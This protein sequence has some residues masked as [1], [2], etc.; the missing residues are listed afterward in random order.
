MRKAVS[1][2]GGGGG[3]DEEKKKERLLLLP[4]RNAT[5]HPTRSLASQLAEER[6]FSAVSVGTSGAPLSGGGG[7]ARSRA[8]IR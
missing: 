1:G 7:A 6:A 5:A 2:E 8:R 3:R 4:S